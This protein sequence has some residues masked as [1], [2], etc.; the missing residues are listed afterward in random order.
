MYSIII[1]T[2]NELSNIEILVKLID[3]QYKNIDEKYELIIVDDN[4]PDKTSEKIE[5][6]MKSYPITLIKRKSKMGLATAYQEALKSVTFDKV[7]IMD[8]DLSHD[9]KHF[10]DF[11]KSSVLPVDIVIGTRYA[12][13]SV[14]GWSL[15]RKLTSRFANNLVKFVLGLNISDVTGSFRLYKKDVLADLLGNIQSRGY[16]VQVELIFM[17]IE[18]GYFVKEVP[19]NFVDRINGKSKCGIKEITGFLKMV[20]MLFLKI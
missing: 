11:I 10:P 9:P 12:N 5:E 13:G 16:A 19:I 7:F 4:S 17:A 6:L 18:R 14:Y 20:G 2:Y 15:L 1:P 8:A 3:I